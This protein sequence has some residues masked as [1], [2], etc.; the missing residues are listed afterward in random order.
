MTIVWMCWAA[1][2]PSNLAQRVG[3]HGWD[4]TRCWPP[5]PQTALVTQLLHLGTER[6]LFIDASWRSRLRHAGVTRAASRV[7]PASGLTW[8]LVGWAGL[9]RQ[10][11][12]RCWLGWTRA[13]L[14]PLGGALW[15]SMHGDWLRG[16]LSH[17]WRCVLRVLLVGVLGSL[18]WGI[19]SDMLRDVLLLC[20]LGIVLM[21]VLK[22][23]GI[24]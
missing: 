8:P 20:I 19:P 21:G 7:P 24:L 6:L 17:M 18:L 4:V 3:R 5:W 15:H 22:V 23:S 9:G 16:I 14:G 2:G 11:G 12:E 10:G 1:H 13:R